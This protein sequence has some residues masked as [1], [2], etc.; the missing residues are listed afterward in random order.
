MLLKQLGGWKQP[1]IS[2]PHLIGTPDKIEQL[3]KNNYKI[4]F[5]VRDPRDRAVSYAHKIKKLNPKLRM[6]IDQLILDI[7]T[8]Y[9][10]VTFNYVSKIPFY[11][12][13][14]DFSEY[15]KLYYPWF[16]YPDLLF[17]YFEK[18]IGPKAGGSRA[19][20]LAEIQKIVNF[21]GIQTSP[22]YIE[23]VANNLWGG[24]ESFRDPKIGRWK[25]TFQQRHKD[26]FKKTG[27]GQFLIDFGYEKGLNW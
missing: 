22:E 15:Y 18:L 26:A 8:K 7:I 10:T 12:N 9:G 19:L 16:Q 4:I 2:E 21:L 23:Y 27:M 5:T 14:S 20:Q 13:M 1:K 17:V 25:D 6:P 3:S 11:K 24:T